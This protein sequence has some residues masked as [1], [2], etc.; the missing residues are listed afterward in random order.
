MALPSH[1][2]L[3][4]VYCIFILFWFQQ[5]RFGTS[6]R[7]ICAAHSSISI[8]FAF[9]SQ[10]LWISLSLSLIRMLK[11]PTHELQLCDDTKIYWTVSA[12]LTH[13]ILPIG[14][15]NF[16]Y[17]WWLWNC[18][19]SKNPFFI[20]SPC[21]NECRFIQYVHYIAW[22]CHFLFLQN[23]SKNEMKVTFFVELKG[24]KTMTEIIKDTHVFRI[25]IEWFCIVL[26]R[27]HEIKTSF[28]VSLCEYVLQSFILLVFGYQLNSRF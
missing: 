26:Y 27:M 19:T 2:L 12:S 25:I 28:L 5:L 11:I 9:H 20:R 22:N 15:Q 3:H 7:R 10:T 21:S 17:E 1:L 23:Q 14:C 18:E 16:A 24:A 4:S 6:R 8:S 13:I